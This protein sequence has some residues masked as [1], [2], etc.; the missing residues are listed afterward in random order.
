MRTILYLSP[1]P[2]KLKATNCATSIR[3]ACNYCMP[4]PTLNALK[5]EPRSKGGRIHPFCKRFAQIGHWL[6]K[7]I[8]QAS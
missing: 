5:V 6:F 4:K 3:T 8:K 2:F 1:P 7:K